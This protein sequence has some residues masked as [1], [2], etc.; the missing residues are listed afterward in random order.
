[1]NGRWTM[2]KRRKRMTRDEAIEALE[3]MIEWGDSYEVDYDACKMSIDALKQEPCEDAISRQA[4][5]Y[6]ASGFCHPSNVADELAKL[7]SV[8]PIRP[9]G[10]W[11]RITNGAMRE[12]YIC[13]KC[14]RQIEEDGVEGLLHIKY[15]YCHCGAKMESEDKE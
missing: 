11:I 7:P 5:V 3:E 12:K 2:S 1:M 9:R 10:H 4:A 13:S 6:V 8:Q 14:G 15:P